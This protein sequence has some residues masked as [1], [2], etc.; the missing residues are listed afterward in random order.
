M[1]AYIDM[2]LLPDVEI[3]LHFLW[4]KLY[5]QI[6]LVLVEAKDNQ[7][8][9]NIGVAFPEYNAQKQYLG[10]KLRLFAATTM[11]LERLN[12]QTKM[13]RLAD[14]V[15][16][17]RI[18]AVPDN[19]RG[20]ALFKRIQPKSNNLRL[21]RRKAKR[22]NISYEQA[23]SIM[24]KHEEQHAKK[25]FVMIKSHTSGKKYPLLIAHEETQQT[26]HEAGFSSYGLSAHST[27]PLF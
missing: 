25:P 27:V 2:T 23:L 26:D 5:Q 8:K 9:I 17:T 22:A 3:P 13:T 14:Y 18:R 19:I 20:H 12:I 7:G 1:K 24:E 16:I 6:H 10:S 21:A 15:H 4:E 11:D